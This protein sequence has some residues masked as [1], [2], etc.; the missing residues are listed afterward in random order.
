MMFPGG[1]MKPLWASL[2][3]FAGSTLW[4]IAMV[5]VFFAG[6]MIFRAGKLDSTRGL[7]LSG[8]A[9]VAY[10]GLTIFGAFLQQLASLPLLLEEMSASTHHLVAV[11]FSVVGGVVDLALFAMLLVGAVKAARGV[12][13]MTPGIVAKPPSVAAK[14]VVAAA[15]PVRE[16]TPVPVTAKPVAANLVAAKPVAITPA[17]PAP[18]VPAPVA[19]ASAARPAASSRV[20]LDDLMPK[21]PFARPTSVRTFAAVPEV[22]PA[23]SI[24]RY[25]EDDVLEDTREIALSSLPF[26]A[27]DDEEEARREATLLEFQLTRPRPSQTI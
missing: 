3:T 15:A 24:A 18:V 27:D 23:P 17:A 20:N 14:P 1:S 7:R 4:F 25:E 6:I 22:A 19:A 13:A 11:V 16:P 26:L 21:G 2:G 10:A 9:L 5:L 12:R 8:L